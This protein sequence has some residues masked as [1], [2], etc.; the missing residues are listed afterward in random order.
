MVAKIGKRHVQ[1]ILEKTKLSGLGTN[2]T[3]NR[4]PER[5]KVTP[6][7]LAVEISTLRN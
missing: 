7:S 1:E 4:E 6:L 2:C 3:G 5:N